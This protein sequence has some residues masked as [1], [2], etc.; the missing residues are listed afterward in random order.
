MKSWKMLLLAGG[1]SFALT[2]G[3]SAADL[4][5]K[6][7]QPPP[8]KPNC[9]ASVW[10][11]LNSSAKDCPLTAYGI[12]V[13]GTIDMGVG[14][15]TWGAPWNRYGNFGNNFLISKAGQG[16]LWAIAPN[17]LSQSNVGVKIKEDIGQGWSIVGLAETGFDPYSLQLANGPR[18]LAQ[19]T[20]TPLPWQS[21]SGDSARAGQWD[22]SQGYIG[23]SNTTFGTLTYGRQNTLLLDAVNAYDPMGGSYA[24]SVIGFSGTTAGGGN[25]ENTR[26]NS[27]FKYRISYGPFRASALAQVGGYA[28]G[29]GSTAAYQGGVGFDWMGF[30]FDGIYSYTADSVK[31]GT[32]NGAIPKPPANTDLVAYD[33]DALKATISNNTSFM[34]VGKYKWNQLTIFGGYEWIQYAAPSD[35]W[36]NWDGVYGAGG[37]T[38][39][40]LGGFQGVNQGNKFFTDEILQVAWGG[41]KY[42]LTPTLDIAAAYYHYNQ[43]F[44]QNSKTFIASCSNAS[45]SNCSGELDAASFMVDWHFFARMDAYAGLMWSQVSNGQANGFYG[46]TVTVGNEKFVYQGSRVN[47]DPT[48]GVRFQF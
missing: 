18:A 11:W 37:N 8:E 12:T 4:P 20:T 44:Y 45:A 27:A 26:S 46:S 34:I 19:N 10:T 21:S 41:A 1:A 40:T 39:T 23:L 47:I 16:G 6:K 28:Q 42:A 14:Y 29:N 35:N 43:G 38:L 13:Y 3:A 24:F 32:Y 17:G 48:F 30:S 15:N 7:D 22:N 33:G 25:T 9:F 31:L 36:A 2:A 5:T